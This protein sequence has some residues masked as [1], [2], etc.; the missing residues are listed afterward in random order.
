ML[1]Y[2]FDVKSYRFTVTMYLFNFLFLIAVDCGLL[3]PL[4]NG[5]IT[6]T[7]GTLVGGVAIHECDEGFIVQ[8]GE[9]R[10]C[11]EGGEWESA[12]I[13]CLKGV[14]MVTYW[15]RVH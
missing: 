6:Y 15:H 13:F 7:P 2:I 4:A 5:T 3:L 14:L 11:L 1:F 10:V 8:G 12:V 9:E